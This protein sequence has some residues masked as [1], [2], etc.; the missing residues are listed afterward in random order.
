MA[1]FFNIWHRPG[2]ILPIFEGTHN[3]IPDGMTKFL[4]PS[5][6]L[7]FRAK[8]MRTHPLLLRSAQTHSSVS[9]KPKPLLNPLLKP[10]LKPLI[11][12]LPKPLLQ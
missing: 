11:K 9:S 3:I 4:G 1:L 10:L 8:L 12:S 6:F 7:Y 2:Q 5:A